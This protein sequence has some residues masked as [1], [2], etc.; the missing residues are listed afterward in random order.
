MNIFTSPAPKPSCLSKKEIEYLERNEKRAD[1]LNFVFMYIV[2]IVMIIII[3]LYI[4]YLRDNWNNPG[5]T[6]YS[7]IVTNHGWGFII[8]PMVFFIPSMSSIV[9]KHTVNALKKKR[10]KCF[11]T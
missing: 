1:G 4:S 8:L 9:V 11:Q 6:L 3:G 10:A 7:E 5:F 2:C